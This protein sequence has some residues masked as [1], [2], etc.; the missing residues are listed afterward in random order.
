[1]AEGAQPLAPGDIGVLGTARPEG[2]QRLLVVG[3]FV[4][5]FDLG[6]GIGRHLAAGLVEV[7]R[8]GGSN[9]AGGKE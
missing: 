4:E 8:I 7:G 9:E 5:P 6:Q 1:M 2:R 3:L